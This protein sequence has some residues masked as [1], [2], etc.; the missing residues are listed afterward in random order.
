MYVSVWAVCIYV[1]GGVCMCLGCSVCTYVCGVYVCVWGRMY[2]C[3][4]VCTYVCGGVCMCVGCM[5]VCG[6]YVCGVYVHLCVGEYACVCD[7]IYI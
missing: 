5:Y 6:V 3:G 7:C 1:C 4:G 2:V